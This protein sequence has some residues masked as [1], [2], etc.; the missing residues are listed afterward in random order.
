MLK[1]IGEWIKSQ[2]G[3]LFKHVDYYEGQFEG[4]DEVVIHPPSC[5]IG[6][7]LGEEGAA[8]D[9]IGNTDVVLYLATSKMARKPGDMLDIIEGIVAKVHKVPVK[10]NNG[11]YG[12]AYV[13][14]WRWRSAFPG[15]IVY[16]LRLRVRR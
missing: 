3:E 14:G 2:V 13:T 15:V 8:E 9:P 7:E 4:I 6:Y 5:F 10:D 12:R 1:E 11:Y 16:E